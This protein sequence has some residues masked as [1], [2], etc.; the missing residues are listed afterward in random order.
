LRHL[1]VS[2][3]RSNSPIGGEAGLRAEDEPSCG[4]S[5]GTSR[6]RLRAHR[7]LVRLHVAEHLPALG[8]RLAREP[9]QAGA[10]F[11]VAQGVD[12]RRRLRRTLPHS[13]PIHEELAPPIVGDQPCRRDVADARISGEPSNVLGAPDHLQHEDRALSAT[14]ALTSG[15]GDVDLREPHAAEGV[16][17]ARRRPHVATRLLHR[18]EACDPAARPGIGV[19]DHSP[20]RLRDQLQAS[21]FPGNLVGVRYRPAN[22]DCIRQHVVPPEQLADLVVPEGA[23]K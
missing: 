5:A 10:D 13:P 4:E 3:L 8:R 12:L 7:R 23:V 2:R 15:A 1:R 11:V 17:L 19:L 9:F 6:H 21:L 16:A 14:H 22:E 18:S 20:A